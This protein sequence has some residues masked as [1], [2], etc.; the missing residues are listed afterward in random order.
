MTLNTDTNFSSRD[1]YFACYLFTK[2]FKLSA[3][4][5]D[6]G[7]LFYWF[8]FDEKEKCEKEEQLF[9]RN[10]VTVKAKGY[11]ETI[12]YLKRKVSR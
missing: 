2:G 7:G 12:K 4:K 9:L 6:G 1:L 8:V 11:A 3:I 10:E 5:R